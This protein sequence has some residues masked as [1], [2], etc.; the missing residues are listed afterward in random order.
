MQS[1][2]LILQS[3]EQA[4][5]KTFL[6]SDIFD[7]PLTRDELWRFLISDKKMSKES[8]D[9]SLQGLSGMIVFKN[10]FYSLKGK[11]HNILKRKKNGKEVHK[12]MQIARKAAYYLS[13]IPTVR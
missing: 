1:N 5:L 13:F 11:E 4:I 12:K 9:T 10:G 8:F 6:Y 2:N 7:F 3:D